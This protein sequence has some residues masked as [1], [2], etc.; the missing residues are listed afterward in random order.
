MKAVLQK[1]E[2]KLRFGLIGVLNTAIDFGMLFL[3]S[4]LG[5]NKYVANT[6]STA[7]AFSFSFFANR[8]FTF[9]SKESMRKQILPFLLVTLTGLWLLQPLVIWLMSLALA[10]LDATLAL[11][12]AKIVATLA[13]LVW[14]YVLYSRFVFKSQ[15]ADNS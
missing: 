8:T 1:H 3:L 4:G 6:I 15:T 14:N 10:S 12:I 13:S 5:L 2:S 9:R 11:F 7:V